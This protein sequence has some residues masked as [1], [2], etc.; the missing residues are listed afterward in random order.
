[1]FE[2]YLQHIGVS[3]LIPHLSTY[4]PDLNFLET[5]QKSSESLTIQDREDLYR[6]QVPKLSPDGS[7][8]LPG[9]TQ[10]DWY[11]L[12]AILGVSELEKKY[13]P[14]THQLARNGEAVK[15]IQSVTSV[16]WLGV[17]KRVISPLG[18]DVLVK[19]SYY[20][21]AS[22]AEFPLTPEFAQNSN[23]SSVGL[24]GKARYFQDLS[25]YEGPYYEC[26]QAVQSEF[27]LP[28]LDENQRV[29]GIIDAESFQKNFFTNERLL[30]LS[31]FGWILGKSDFF[32]EGTSSFM[33]KQFS[34][35]Q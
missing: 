6:Y 29:I 14:V 33:T 13:H 28:I 15:C 27:C 19:I 5:V 1:M 32:R 30:T 8:G 22:R 16:D 34:R 7:C 11:D 24:S 3:E 4:S 35:Q 9:S 25:V 2:T 17:Y 31:W 10:L 12:S 21:R 23:N 26:D 18:E 20:G